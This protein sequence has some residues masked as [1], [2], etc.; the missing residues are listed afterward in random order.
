MLLNRTL[1]DFDG[2]DTTKSSV[3]KQ[4]E[5]LGSYLSADIGKPRLKGSLSMHR[6]T[7]RKDLHWLRKGA[8]PSEVEHESQ[9]SFPFDQQSNLQRVL[10]RSDLRFN[11]M[12]GRDRQ[13]IRE[14]LWRD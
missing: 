9:T 8:L 10:D 11:K 5:Y 14:K 6:M 7:K 2:Y 3:S 13:P 1:N 4:L 12:V